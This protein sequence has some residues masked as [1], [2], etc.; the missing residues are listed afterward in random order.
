MCG[1][2]KE[3]T[4]IFG[5]LRIKLRKN[6]INGRRKYY[7]L[8]GVRKDLVNGMKESFEQRENICI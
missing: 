3:Y 5:D 6:Y 8:F 7:D 2:A 1:K 4:I